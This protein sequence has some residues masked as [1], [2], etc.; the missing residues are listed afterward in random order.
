MNKNTINYLVLVIGIVLL[1]GGFYSFWN[2]DQNPTLNKGSIFAI[3]AGVFIVSKRLTKTKE[4]PSKGFKERL[5][6]KE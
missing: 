6:N 5:K 3:I 2:S 4:L 1:V